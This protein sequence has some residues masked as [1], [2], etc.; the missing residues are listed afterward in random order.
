MLSRV[1]FYVRDVS[2]LRSFYQEHLSLDVCEE[3]E[4]EW[5]VLK[6]GDIE[7]ALHRVGKPYRE[8]ELQSTASNVK[9]VFSVES[10]LVEL[11]EKLV[12]KGVRMRELKRYG[13]FPY[14]LCDGEDPEGNVFQ[15]SQVCDAETPA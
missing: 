10:G 14:L 2:R 15:L 3:I 12:G 5:A 4:G 13:G 6:A 9:I 8:M 1:I 7:L 11:R